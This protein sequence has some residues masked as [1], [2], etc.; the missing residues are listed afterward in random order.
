MQRD[1][2]GK[3]TAGARRRRGEAGQSL[4][5]AIIVL[6]IL[7]FVGGLFIALVARNLQQARR[8]AQVSGANGFAEAGLRYMD[9]QLMKSPE[10][11]DWRT[12]PDDVPGDQDGDG[13]L[14]DINRNDPDFFWLKE[15]DP[16]TGEGGFTRVTFG[17]PSATRGNLG[18]RALV[19]ITYQ[20][21]PDDPNSK[22]LKLESVGRVG[23]INPN[24]PTTFG[25]S[26]RAGL[27]RELVA[28]KSIGIIDYA[29]FVT[30]KDRKP[31]AASF[32]SA[33]LVQDRNT[34]AT[35]DAPVLRDIESQTVGPIR[36]NGDVTFYGDN[37][38]TL[39]PGRGDQI[40][41]AGRIRLNDV[42]P[43]LLASDPAPAKGSTVG[44]PIGRLLVGAAGAAAPTNNNVLPSDSP[45]FTTLNGF[46][47]D[48]VAAPDVAGLPR[49]ISRLEPPVI[50]APTG[51]NGLTRFRAL[52]R[53]AT[54]LSP[55]ETGPN[56]VAVGIRD[57]GTAG[58]IGWGSG[59]YI[60][61]P[62]D[63]QTASAL[64]SG[65]ATVRGDWLQPTSGNGGRRTPYWDGDFTYT[66]PGVDIELTPRYMRI[67]QF[68]D[69]T[70]G[71]TRSIFRKPDGTPLR[72]YTQTIRYTYV[73]KLGAGAAQQQPKA[74]LAPD[75]TTN[76]RF[77]FAGYPQGDFVI[78]AEGNIRIR[79][80]AGGLDP[81]TRR[82][83]LRHLTF[84]SNGTIY[85]DGNLLRD[86][87][88][89]DIENTSDQDGFP[90]ANIKGRSSIALLARDYIC[91]NT[92]QFLTP[93]AS[94][95][96]NEPGTGEV[97]R[98][99]N[100]GNDPFNFRLT[101]GPMDRTNATP[102]YLTA[103]TDAAGLPSVKFFFRHGSEFT[104]AAPGTEGAAINLFVNSTPAGTPNLFDFQPN[105]QQTLTLIVPSLSYVDQ[106]FD[107]GAA[108]PFLFPNAPNNGA[109]FG[110]NP[111]VVGL[112]NLLAINYD[113]SPG[114]DLIVP[115]AAYKL[116]RLGVAPLDVRIE[117]FMYAQ[118]ESFFIIPGPWFNPDP[119]DTYQG[120]INGIDPSTG[121][122]RNRRA[123]EDTILG[124]PRRVSH[125]FPFYRQP[126][127]VRIT[128]YGSVAENQTAPVGDQ[129]AWLEKWGW[130]PRFM[131]STGLPDTGGSPVGEQR[132]AHGPRG[133]YNDPA[134]IY[135]FPAKPYPTGNPPADTDSGPGN[136]I[137]FEFDDR[138][139]L[140]YVRKP[141]GTFLLDNNGRP[142]PLRADVYGRTLPI[143][144]RLPVAQGLLFFGENPVRQ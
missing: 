89:P 54:A 100:S 3:K 95:F 64:L 58:I 15:F 80:V 77:K 37:L 88:T 12:L 123:D 30:N 143:V 90:L 72:G 141:D 107:V 17:G 28:Y 23:T 137:L 36:I 106:V 56:P 48:G 73:P 5:V 62:N 27:R 129:G 101:P 133:V 138:A 98:R 33:R 9:D 16:T 94:D 74:G 105:P 35:T 139:I 32:G 102:P 66:P 39:V 79:G 97:V 53:D 96:T 60:N 114:G 113:V 10:G 128:L 108:N 83:F 140:P 1:V 99:I 119:N 122:P 87:I 120:Y 131:G 44:R 25:N 14:V 2:R 45:Q 127:D 41:I 57:D 7:L 126:Q 92:T 86:N 109:P 50:D 55:N 81:E 40:E 112:G 125:F 91:V 13:S 19:R 130:V 11:A 136:G 34:A 76:P 85:V 21:R 22:Y 82:A 29:R 6:F 31:T 93:G 121:T 132:T 78:F 84:V 8:A 67:T 75:D 69:S 46:V 117:A 42:S 103:T 68:V 26:E 70:A 43:T 144:P 118:E 65:G 116:S 63:V 104:T 38:F 142:I 134:A 135:K 52:T 59:L 47:R 111:P 115:R 61:N 110:L 71:R 24:D 51:P 20:P 49:S 4:V 124:T 18:G